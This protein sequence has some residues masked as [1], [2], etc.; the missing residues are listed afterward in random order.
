METVEDN[1]VRC[2]IWGDNMY[3]E[4]KNPSPKIKIEQDYLKFKDSCEYQSFFNSLYITGFTCTTF[5]NSH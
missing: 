3:W 2:P 1:L 4:K 5:D